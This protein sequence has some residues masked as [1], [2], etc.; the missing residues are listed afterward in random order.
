[1]YRRRM[2]RALTLLAL[3]TFLTAAPPA[4]ARSERALKA[5][6]KT[7]KASRD[8]W[9]ERAQDRQDELD[10]TYLGLSGDIA[11]GV[12]VIAAR[13]HVTEIHRLV[14]EPIR[15]AW[16]CGST[17]YQGTSLWSLDVSLS[18]SDFVNG[19]V[20]EKDCSG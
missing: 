16:P 14:F 13:G 1:M 17:L 2:S 6:I 12:R 15:V 4:H 18:D 7:L 20:V 11:A 3:L 8:M 10:D 9:K 5:Q 19:E